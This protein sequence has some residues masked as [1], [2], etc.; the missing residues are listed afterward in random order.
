M[1]SFS[2][3]GLDERILKSVAELGWSTLTD[4]QSQAIPLAL[5]GKDV[6]VRAKTGSGKT[7]AYG[8]PL[9]QRVLSARESSTSSVVRALVLVPSKELCQQTSR[10]L[11]SLSSG[12]SKVVRIVEL[13]THTSV[14]VQRPIILEKPDIVVGTPSR[15]VA[16]LQAKN[17]VIR[18]SLE[19]LVIDEADLVFS[20]GYED[21]LTVIIEYLPKIYQA[22]LMSATLSKDTNKLGRLVLHNPVTLDV[23]ERQAENDDSQLTQYHIRCEADDKFLLIYA[24]LKLKLVRGKSLIFVNL[25]DR[26][27]RLKLFLEQFSIAACVLNSELPVNSRMHIV[28]EFNRGIYDY[29]IASDERLDK[30]QQAATRT[31]KT[32]KQR[33]D[34]EYGIARG[35][36][37]QGVENVINFDFPPTVDAYVHRVGRTARGKECGTALSLVCPGEEEGRLREA[38]K[39]L[40]KGEVT[41]DSVKPYQFKMSEI[42]GFRYRVMDGLRRVTQTAVREAR[43]KEIRTEII[44][45]EKLKAHFQDN[46]RDLQVLRHDRN[47]HPLPVD[48]HLK[49]VPSYLV[50]A[51]LKASFK[52]DMPNGKRKF[53][54][55]G[56]RANQTKGSRRKSDPLRSFKFSKQERQGKRAKLE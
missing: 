31:K 49:H 14:A 43:L 29:I 52:S 18:D 41:A 56:F 16:H 19:M 34:K 22:F 37:F 47:L 39:R 46:P 4:V 44:N 25:I 26:C 3:L 20:F 13:S 15:V 50:P 17:L 42:D 6:L 11:K 2:S 53:L 28:D 35:I 38:V 32:K 27:Y 23:D 36:D 8:I 24:L 5:D 45:S 54:M 9:I 1:S 21:D 51:P 12:C 7:A 55:R 40:S 48:E 30:Q 33:K 10:M